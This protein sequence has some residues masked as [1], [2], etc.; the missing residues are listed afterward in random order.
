MST[1]NWDIL[2]TRLASSIRDGVSSAPTNGLELSVADRDAYLNYSY[3]KFVGLVYAYNPLSIGSLLRELHKIVSVSATSG[4]IILP[5]D[6]GLYV[7]MGADGVVVNEP[8]SIKDFIGIKHS[9]TLQ[10]PASSTNI[11]IHVSSLTIEILPSTLSG[12][13]SLG[14]ILKPTSISQGGADDIVLLST[15]WDT[16]VQ[17]ARAEYYRD[18]LEF[19]IAQSIENDAIRRSPIKIGELK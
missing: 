1:P 16:I 3:G 15:H 13:F 9:S 7:S 19:E 6:F 14:Y 10:N 2:H 11:Y 17:F 8:E 5:T 4:V 12:S 18:K